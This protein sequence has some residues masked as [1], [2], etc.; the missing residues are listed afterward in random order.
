M[1]AASVRSFVGQE[2][3]LLVADERG[4]ATRGTVILAHGGGQTRHAWTATA[5]TLA[6]SGW[7]AISLDLRGHG[8]SAW[9][10]TGDY[11]IEAFAEDLR[12]VTAQIGGRPAIVGASLGGLAGLFV[13]ASLAPRTFSSLTLVDITPRMDPAG[14]AKIMGFMGKHIE[15]GFA[16]LEE[17]AEAISHYLP[18][19]PPR[20]VNSGLRK[21]LRLHSDGRYRWHWDPRFVTSVMERRAQGGEDTFDLSLDRLALPVHLVR[22]GMSEL[23][24]PEAAAE[25]VNSVPGA[26]YTDVAGA[27]HMVVGDKNDAFAAAVI[28]FLKK[29]GPRPQ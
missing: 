27:G 5:D 23:V 7:R 1:S 2:A 3:N 12:C 28:H 14:V 26:T 9:S 18:Y 10:R 22:G 21:N 8:D 6:A 11:R 24:S 20:S 16:S 15:R 13:E 4:A 25:F 17:A 19:R 29:N